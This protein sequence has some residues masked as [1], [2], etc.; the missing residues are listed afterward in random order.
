MKM[1]NSHIFV[2]SFVILIIS[3]VFSC[4]KPDNPLK[5]QKG[6]FPDSIINIAAIN[7]AYDDY[8]L[9]TSIFLM[10]PIL[11]FSQAT[12]VVMEVSMTWFMG[13]LP[14]PSARRRVILP[15]TVK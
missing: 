11:W 7:S 9:L 2:S 1:F 3:S 4:K 13:F 15:W 14:I 8:N 10:E 6:T 12:G 5:F